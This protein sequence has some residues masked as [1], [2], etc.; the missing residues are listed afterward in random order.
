MRSNKCFVWAAVIAVLCVG[1][2]LQAAVTFEF[3]G[4]SNNNP[5]DVAIGEAQLFMDVSD[6][7]N[8][9]VLFTFRNKGPEDCVITAIYFHDERGVLTGITNIAG[10]E[11]VIFS[12]DATPGNLPGGRG[13]DPAFVATA[14]ADADQPGGGPNASGVA[15]EKWVDITMGI[16]EGY[17]YDDVLAALTPTFPNLRVGLHVTAFESG[18]SESFVT[19]VPAPGAI[20]LVGIGTTLVGLLRRRQSL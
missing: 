6:A 1:G 13:L 12:E 7:G 17:S 11:G 19:V 16:V 2:T 18:G 15:P 10:S 5:D 9:E 4:I 8:N 14:S 3:T 20:V